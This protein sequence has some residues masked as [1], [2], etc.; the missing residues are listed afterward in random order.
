[1]KKKFKLSKNSRVLLKSSFL[2]QAAAGLFAPL[3]AIFVGR[4]GGS[5]LD[6]GIAYA[7]FACLT[8]I[9]ILITGM[10]NFFVKNVRKVIVLGYCLLALGYIGYLFVSKP[11]HLFIIQIILGIAIG[12]LD[13]S[14]D[15]LYALNLCQEDALK[16]WTIWTGCVYLIIGISA[17]IGS[18][19][20]QKFSFTV[21]FSIMALFSILS[22][23]ISFKILGIER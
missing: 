23:I 20:V 1:M 11:W 2:I 5:I 17:L 15:S 21:L 3:Y 18:F 22:A 9:F 6:V 13:P 8:G 19:I 10:S 7:L 14:W 16:S 4:I 12:V